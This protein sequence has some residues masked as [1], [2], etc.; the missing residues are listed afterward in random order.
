ML[1]PVLYMISAPDTAS[2]PRSPA[3]ST[4]APDML[5][6]LKILSRKRSE[7][8]LQNSLLRPRLTLDRVRRCYFDRVMQGTE[9]RAIVREQAV[10]AFHSFAHLVRCSKPEGDVNSPNHQ[11]TLFT[12]N[13]A[14]DTGYEPAV[15]RVNFA[16]FQRA[17][18]GSQHSAGR[19]GND[20]V[21]GGGVRF[22]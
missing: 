22:A 13:L 3:P 16:R 11:H 14:A 7:H 2:A 1:E 21:D 6:A 20:V 9:Q 10:C 8:T 19:G 17:A 4:A 15:A 12:F 18:E 5:D